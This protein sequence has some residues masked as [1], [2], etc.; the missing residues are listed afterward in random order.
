MVWDELC[1]K[2]KAQLPPSNCLPAESSPYTCSVA[3]LHSGRQAGWTAKP[4][5][6]AQHRP[7]MSFWLPMHIQ[8]I[9]HSLQGMQKPSCSAAGNETQ[10]CQL[11]RLSMHWPFSV[12]CMLYCHRAGWQCQI[13]SG[14]SG[15]INACIPHLLLKVLLLLICRFLWM[16]CRNLV[17]LNFHWCSDVLC[18]SGVEIHKSNIWLIMPSSSKSLSSQR[19]KLYHVWQ[20]YPFMHWH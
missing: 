6:W 20:S 7:H 9:A 18:A 14:L 11:L 2:T 13:P 16:A 15:C 12:W 1:A 19:E 17:V 10:K 3:L 4:L 8:F 5:S